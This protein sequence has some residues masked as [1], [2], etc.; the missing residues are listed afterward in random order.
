M[1][2]RTVEPG[3]GEQHDSSTRSTKQHTLQSSIT[4]E[5]PGLMHGQEAIVTIDP[6]PPGHGI[7]FER[8]YRRSGLHFPILVYFPRRVAWI[9]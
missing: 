9:G 5:G 3:S 2:T 8:R 7:V 1:E 4:V 6:A